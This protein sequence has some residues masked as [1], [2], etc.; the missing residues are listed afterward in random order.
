MSDK[1]PLDDLPW[2]KPADPSTGISESIRRE[3]THALGHGQCARAHRRAALSL[4]FPALAIGLFTFLA[5]LRGDPDETL[6]SALYGV[7]GWVLVLV[8]VLTTG[9]AF[10]PGR[11][12]SR[13][14]R[15]AAAVAIPA[16]FMLY[17]T[18]TASA[19]SPFSV[20]SQGAP[21]HH[22]LRC[23]ITCLMLGA[24]VSGGVLFL[25]RG[26]DPLTPTL[27]G[28]LAGLTGGLGSALALGVACPSHEAWHVGISHGL[29]VVAMVG[30]GALVGRR[31][32]SP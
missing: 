20:F 27:S 19:H 28:A 15:I 7:A 18:A 5:I 14:L 30:I 23:G 32:L 17:I 11:R 26:T 31:L 10:P 13:T 16:V 8:V 25:W 21:A 1:D 4:L 9:L 6:R 12:P 3:C 24:L 22:A 2:P 29:V